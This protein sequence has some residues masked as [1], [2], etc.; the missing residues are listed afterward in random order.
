MAERR[1]NESRPDNC[2]GSH[3]ARFAGRCRECT[4]GVLPPSDAMQTVSSYDLACSG[5]VLRHY[6]QEPWW[7]R[8]A[9]A[10]E[11]RRAAYECFDAFDL[12]A[13]TDEIR[14]RTHN[15]EIDDADLES[16]VRC[17]LSLSWKVDVANGWLQIDEATD[18]ALVAY[19][20]LE[21]QNAED[22]LGLSWRMVM[23][24]PPRF[25]QDAVRS[26]ATRSYE[27][28]AADE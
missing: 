10:E 27:I 21:I 18:A 15:D 1:S 17:L 4:A 3:G 14:S 16:L 26:A 7:W 25:V 23:D 6:P 13:L 2:D 8:E 28:E 24:L 5:E 9:E 12:T 19:R 11:L 20:R 22:L